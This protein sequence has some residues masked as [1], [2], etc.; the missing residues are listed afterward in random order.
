MMERGCAV[1]LSSAA[2]LF[3][4]LVNGVALHPRCLLS[5]YKTPMEVAHAFSAPLDEIY[6]YIFCF[7]LSL[8]FSFFLFLYLQSMPRRRE[9]GGGGGGEIGNKLAVSARIV[10]LSW[11][12]PVHIP[13][14]RRTWV[15]NSSVSPPPP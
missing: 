7:L 4:C 8:F 1:S 2:G 3:G 5:G 14:F 6:L 13:P 12:L 11:D 9:G 15:C 10:N